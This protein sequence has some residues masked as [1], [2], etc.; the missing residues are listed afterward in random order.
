LE[1]I[2]GNIATPEAAIALADAGAE[3]SVKWA[4]DLDLS[5]PL[6]LL[7]VWAFPPAFCSFRMR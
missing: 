7:Q 1:V 6:E 4:L 2:V 3:C 5:A